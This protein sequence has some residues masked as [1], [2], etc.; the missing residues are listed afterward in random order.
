MRTRNVSQQTSPRHVTSH[1]EPA[2][3][4]PTGTP[5][6]AVIDVRHVWK[7][8]GEAERTVH[9]LRDVSLRVDTGD[10]VAIM[11][12]SGS[13]KSTLMNVLGC[14]DVQ[15][16]GSYT[17]DGVD[18]ARL[19]EYQ[20]SEIR[21]RKLGFVFQSFNLIPRMTARANVELPMMYAGVNAS[22][23]KRRALAALDMVGL[24]ERLTHTPSQMSGG[25]QQR[26]AIARSL[27]NTPAM[28]LAD[29]P[30]GALDSVSTAE[31]LNIFDR[32]NQAGRTLVLITHED[33]VA[34][35]AKRVVVMRDGRIVSD[36]A[37]PL[38]ADEPG[39]VTT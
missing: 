17:L 16:K 36:T 11:G 27:V 4:T 2:L 12:A 6:R 10:Y 28:I 13:G 35:R 24:S 20:L 33:E 3:S 37:Q 30:T 25:Q 31:V 34:A 22:E 14:L 1:A 29:E 32:L 15:T 23:R 8:Y 39:Q 26:V 7:T 9:A 19:K 5:T 18:V 21:N 38:L